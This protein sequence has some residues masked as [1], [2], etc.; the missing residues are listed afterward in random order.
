M[1]GSFDKNNNADLPKGFTLIEL[2]VVVA[3]IAMLLAIL[4]PS[5]RSARAIAKRLGCG[6]NLKQIAV[7]WDMYLNDNDE[8]F[9]QGV[10][11]VYYTYGGWNGLEYKDIPDDEIPF[12]P[13][14]KYV[15]LPGKIS[16]EDEAE[17][18]RCPAD[19]GGA[20]GSG[21]ALYEKFYD[22]Y[23]TSYCTN[24]FLVGQSNIYPYNTAVADLVDEINFRMPGIRRDHIDNYS[25]VVLAG[26]MGWLYQWDPD[27]PLDER[28]KSQIEWH[29]K[30]D[31]YNMVF[32]DG[33]VEFLEI[34]EGYFVTAEYS[35][36]PYRDLCSMAMKVQGTAPVPVP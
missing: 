20:Y 7:A 2:L 3:I 17:V 23:G 10:N 15:D 29:Q 5:L 9:Y 8:R 31:M 11:N 14:N 22:I 1:S 32:L 34:I 26:D 21:Y 4:F 18:Y 30:E 35:F 13:L 24:I 33:H 6:A 19:R 27:V 25:R 36:L 12:R 28:W 16:S